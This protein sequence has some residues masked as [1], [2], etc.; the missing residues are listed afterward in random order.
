MLLF[1]YTASSLKSQRIPMLQI[2][3]GWLFKEPTLK[4]TLLLFFITLFLLCVQ[5]YYMTP[6]ND[7]M[8]LIDWWYT[9][10]FLYLSFLTQNITCSTLIKVKETFWLLRRSHCSVIN[11]AHVE[12]PFVAPRWSYMPEWLPNVGQINYGANCSFFGAIL[13]PSV[14]PPAPPMAPAGDIMAAN[15]AVFACIWAPSC[16][17]TS[18]A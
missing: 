14:P 7:R 11:L 16:L 15:R 6:M 5:G 3:I 13:A 8:P 2:G 4:L 9:V 10:P 18:C 17:L 1:Y 12:E